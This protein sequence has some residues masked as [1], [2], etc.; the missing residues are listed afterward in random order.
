MLALYLTIWLAVALLVAGETGRARTPRESLA[1]PWAWWAFS[2]G[3]LLALV[4]TV[5][6]F[7]VVHRWVH[8]DAVIATAEQTQRVFGVRAGWGVYVNYAFFTIWLAD[9]VWWRL[10]PDL[11]RRPAWLTAALRAFYFIILVNGAVIFAGGMRRL[12]G[13]ALVVWLLRIWTS[14]PGRS[15]RPADGPAS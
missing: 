7:D 14:P 8:E 2:V 9:A 13:L 11:S 12:L 10:E 15:V 4:H 6:A 1:P 5:L 3:L